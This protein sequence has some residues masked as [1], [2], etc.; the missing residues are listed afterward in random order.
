MMNYVS[1]QSIIIFLK[2]ILAALF[3]IIIEL[4]KSM[5]KYWLKPEYNF[6]LMLSKYF[7][8]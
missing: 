8:E 1:N 6:T 7:R 4:L 2:T 3:N 5:G